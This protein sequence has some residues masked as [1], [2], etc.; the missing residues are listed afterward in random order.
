[1]T[2]S[3]VRLTL[4]TVVLTQL[5]LTTPDRAQAIFHTA[6][7][8]A[9]DDTS[10]QATIRELEEHVEAAIVSGDTE[11]LQ[12]VFAEDFRYARTSGQVENKVKWLED[13][14]RRPFLA[15]K[16]ISLDVE[17][18][19]NVAVTHGQL[20]MTVR[21]DHGGHSNLLRYLRVYEQRNG[22]WQMLSHRSL[23]ETVVKAAK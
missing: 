1:M 17:I 4:A 20:E 12:T 16:I 13:V 22:R 5:I 15:R 9:I 10:V 7:N 8:V 23:D 6:A 3:I 21:D 19:G 18:H 2:G 14:A 11:F